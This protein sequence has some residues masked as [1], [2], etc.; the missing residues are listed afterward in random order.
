MQ[1][2]NDFGAIEGRLPSTL[3]K[4]IRAIAAMAAGAI[5]GLAMLIWVGAT[6]ADMILTGLL[7]AERASDGVAWEGRISTISTGQ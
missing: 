6:L 2:E 5:F 4:A 1:A 7:T 3:S